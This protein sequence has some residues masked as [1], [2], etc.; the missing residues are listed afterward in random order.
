[1]GQLHRHGS[2]SAELPPGRSEDPELWFRAGTFKRFHQAPTPLISSLKE[3]DGGGKAA[4][5]TVLL[6]LPWQS[7]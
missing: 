7:R 4:F 3:E 5:Q 2:T 6:S 1:M